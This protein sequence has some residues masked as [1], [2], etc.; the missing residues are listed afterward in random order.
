MSREACFSPYMLITSALQTVFGFERRSEQD[1]QADISQR[2]QIEL[3][4]AREEFQDELEAEKVA[5]MRAKMA[6]ARKYRAEERFDQTILQH[7]TEELKTFFVKSLPIQQ[8]AIPILLDIAQ[9]YKQLEYSNCPLNV[10]LLHTKQAALNYND[11]CNE[12]DKNSLLIGNV[13][14]R[15]WCN[16]DIAHNSAILNL[17][18]IMS[19]IPTL[20]IS[21][22]FQGGSIHFTASMWDAQSDAKPLIRPLFSIPCPANYLASPQSFTGEGKK[23]IESRMALISTIVSG[24]ARDSYMLMSQGRT[25][26]LPQFLKN[27]QDVLNN[28]LKDENKELRSFILN[29]Y[30]A[31]E[32]LLDKADCPT[33]LFNPEEIKKLGLIANK[34]SKELQCLTHNDYFLSR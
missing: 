16:K 2:H 30:K 25:P 1:K 33:H 31:M 29:E 34:A 27:N 7:R 24:C 28:L 11:I 15:R 5:S 4:N 23:A 9:N 21:P 14:Y 13:E 12:L 3:R 20:V 18:A 10:V 8:Q 6:V 17:H 32:Q 22:N 26:T 19:N